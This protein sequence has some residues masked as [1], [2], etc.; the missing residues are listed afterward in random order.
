MKISNRFPTHK[1]M[2]QWWNDKLIYV[3]R[4]GR[5]IIDSRGVGNDG[6]DEKP[7]VM[8][9]E[10]EVRRVFAGE[11]RVEE[12]GI[13]ELKFIKAAVVETLRLHPPIAA[14]EGIQGEVRDQW[15]RDTSE[16]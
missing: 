5:D 14:S 8:K 13:H 15:I 2:H 10:A 6:T 11:G 7:R 3:L 9:A 4:W 1:T 16:D 12:S